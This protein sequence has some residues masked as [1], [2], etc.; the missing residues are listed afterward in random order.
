MKHY[1]LDIWTWEGVY[2]ASWGHHDPF[3]FLV[4]LASGHDFHVPT[5]TVVTHGYAR[6]G[7]SGEDHPA[8]C[9]YHTSGPGR[10]VR[11]ITEVELF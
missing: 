10:G 8:R 1:P 4:A 7:F 5:G 9:V 11:P 6:V 2:A 3:D